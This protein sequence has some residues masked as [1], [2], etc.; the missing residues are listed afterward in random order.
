M[1]SVNMSDK[2]CHN[3]ILMNVPD[4]EL[5]VLADMYR[6]KNKLTYASNF[7]SNGQRIRKKRSFFVR[8]SSIGNSWRS[9]GT[10]FAVTEV[11]LKEKISEVK[12]KL[13]F[14]YT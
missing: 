12:T 14:P 2:I 1:Y 5:E 7:L 10:F 3:E 13:F 11:R 6:E 4:E 9:D 8:F